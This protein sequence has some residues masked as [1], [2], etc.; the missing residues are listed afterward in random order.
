MT[1]SSHQPPPTKLI[2]IY[3]LH[4]L[5][6]ERGNGVVGETRKPDQSTMKVWF[7]NLCDLLKTKNEIGGDK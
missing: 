4:T 3:N 7:K 2:D 5:D 1:D 6:G